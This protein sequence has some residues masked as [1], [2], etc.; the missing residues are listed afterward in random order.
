[1]RE[2]GKRNDR[3]GSRRP[4][5]GSAR[6]GGRRSGGYGRSNRDGGSGGFSGGRR[7]GGFGGRSGGYGGVRSGGFDRR[8]S[9]R[10]EERRMHKV[11][12]DGCGEE[13]EV[14]FKPTDT[15]PVYCNECFKGKGKS[16]GSANCNCKEELEK[17]NQKLEIISKFIESMKKQSASNDK[18]E[19]KKVKKVTK[20]KPKKKAVKKAT[21]KKTVKK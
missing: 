5:G 20:K 4:E 17:I 2:F 14:P 15:K 3:E 11:T 16:K 6:S 8:S 7:S 10:R 18:V 13:C 1:M 19:V 9:R 12:C 21:K